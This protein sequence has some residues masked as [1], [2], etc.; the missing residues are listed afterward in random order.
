MKRSKMSSKNMN[1][2]VIR[3]HSVFIFALIFVSWERAALLRKGGFQV[4][5]NNVF[6]SDESDINTPESA[7]YESFQ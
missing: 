3:P 4:A 1:D 6:L 7:E 5:A 2:E